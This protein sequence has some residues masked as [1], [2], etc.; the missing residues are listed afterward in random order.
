MTRNKICDFMDELFECINDPEKVKRVNGI[1]KCGFGDGWY[2]NGTRE[3]HVKDGYLYQFTDSHNNFSFRYSP[4][5][6]DFYLKI[7]T[8]SGYEFGYECGVEWKWHSHGNGASILWKKE[9][10]GEKPQYMKFVG[11]DGPI[12]LSKEEYEKLVE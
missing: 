6:K 4:I 8:T 5:K 12:E 10:K 3:I 11:N 2:A 7:S 1:I 9:G